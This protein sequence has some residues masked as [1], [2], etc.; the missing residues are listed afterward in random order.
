M[1]S[2]RWLQKTGSK[3]SPSRT[4]YQSQDSGKP[5]LKPHPSTYSKFWQHWRQKSRPLKVK[6]C[7]RHCCQQLQRGPSGSKQDWRGSA[8]RGARKVKPTPCKGKSPTSA[9]G[10]LPSGPHQ[11]GSLPPEG[12]FSSVM[13]CLFSQSQTRKVQWLKPVHN[14]CISTRLPLLFLHAKLH[15]LNPWVVSFSSCKTS[16][17]LNTQQSWR[18]SKD[19]IQNEFFK[20]QIYW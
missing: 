19:Q 13:I 20:N 4:W 8:G 3:S 10:S 17:F 7:F 1:G 18:E 16:F 2:G 12:E 5:F 15:S 11:K 14:W 6:G 9:A